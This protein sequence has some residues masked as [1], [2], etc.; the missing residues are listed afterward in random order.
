[1][2]KP[3][4]NCDEPYWQY[5]RDAVIGL[6]PD[7]ERV[8]EFVDS[9]RATNRDVGSVRVLCGPDGGRILDRTGTSHGLLARFVRLIENLGYDQETFSLFDEGLGKGESIVAVPTSRNECREVGQLMIDHNGHAVFYFG[10]SSAI[11]LTGP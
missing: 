1:V 9:L 2:T 4:L 11:S 6:L 10:N 3:L 5:L 8:E 7:T